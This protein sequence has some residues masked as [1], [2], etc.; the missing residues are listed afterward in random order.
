MESD[1]ALSDGRLFTVM[2]V[3]YGIFD[4]DNMNI[5]C[6]INFINSAMV[7]TLSANPLIVAATVLWGDADKIIY[8]PRDT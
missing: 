3:F 1:L 4:G 7:G 6:S 2:Q 8:T 5:A